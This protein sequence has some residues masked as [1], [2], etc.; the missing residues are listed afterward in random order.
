[1]FLY[2][3]AKKR[4]AIYK[5]AANFNWKGS[6]EFSS[7]VSVKEFKE[8]VMETIGREDIERKRTGLDNV[9]IAEEMEI[10]EETLAELQEVCRLEGVTLLELVLKTLP[11]E[12]W[13]LI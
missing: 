9:T 7:V 12:V 4:N 3:E 5:M 2:N 8:Q 1:M 11:F 10:A 6:C 13:K